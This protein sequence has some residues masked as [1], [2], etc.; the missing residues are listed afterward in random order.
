MKLGITPLTLGKRIDINYGLLQHAES[1]GF[2]S[3]WTSEAY[4]SDAVSV[5][6]WMLAKTRKIKVGTAIMQMPARAPAM[7]AM[8]AISLD[9]LSGGRF[10][11]G[12]GPSGPQV[13]EGWYGVPYGKPLLRT[14][15]YIS[16]LRSIFARNTALVHQG[17]HYQIPV[18]G[19]GSMGLGKPLKC[20]LHGNPDL[21]IYT[22]A[23]SPNGLRLAGEIADG[24]LPL[25]MSPEKTNLIVDH[26]REGQIKGGREGK[27]FEI[28][29]GVTTVLVTDKADLAK[30]R[31]PAKETLALYIGGMG[32]RGK[33]FYN[34][35]CKRLGYEE[36]AEKI[37]NAYLRGD[38]SEAIAQVPDELVDELFLIGT[39]DYLRDR[40]QVWRAASL[41]GGVSTMMIYSQQNRALE[42]LA[43]ELL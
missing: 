4:G 41:T 31:M 37:Q 43:E 6:S 16:I 10:I 21:P 20:I 11:L 12:L 19:P 28:I 26:I 17:E 9:Q 18:S 39:E 1:L 24:V 38:Q 34:D 36:A 7:T 32:A 35:F 27:P 30:A 29:V 33:N 3:A 8:T 25:W 14:R 2:D 42:I 15:E 22:A 40:I 23:I 13:V 5:A